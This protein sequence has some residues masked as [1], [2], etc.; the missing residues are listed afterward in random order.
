MKTYL[1]IGKNAPD[2]EW[3]DLIY[4]DVEAGTQENRGK[5]A[6]SIDIVPEE[7]AQ[8]RK[9]GFGRDEPNTNPFLP[10]PV[11]RRQFSL[12]LL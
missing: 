8:L 12:N 10:P 4:K 5:L 2:A 7:E 3:I 6:I 9:A 1:G 11:G